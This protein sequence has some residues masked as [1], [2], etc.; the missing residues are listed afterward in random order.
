MGKRWQNHRNDAG[1]LLAALFITTLGAGSCLFT[2]AAMSPESLPTAAAVLG[3]IVGLF[4][5]W[6]ILQR[7]GKLPG[8]DMGFLLSASRNHRDDGLNEYE[9][10]LRK[11]RSLPKVENRPITAEEAHQIKITS[12]NTWVPA[13]TDR[14]RR[15]AEKSD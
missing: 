9:P 5:L 8:L 4:Y 13:A 7:F 10:R 15:A 1:S 2:V 11:S 14:T 6:V 12:P 3:T